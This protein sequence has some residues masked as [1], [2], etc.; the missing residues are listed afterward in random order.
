MIASSTR[1][2]VAHLPSMREHT[3]LIAWQVADELAIAVYRIPTVDW[4]A[5]SRPAWDQ[6]RRACLSVP[7]NLAEG[8][9]WRPGRRWVFHLR[10]ANGSASETSELLR[11][12]QRLDALPQPQAQRLVDL[13]LRSGSLIH[14]LMKR[15]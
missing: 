2:G 1:I 6:V 11:F 14:G 10:V 9:R 3:S 15:A 5:P 8:Y 4:R 12:L 7:L 13:S